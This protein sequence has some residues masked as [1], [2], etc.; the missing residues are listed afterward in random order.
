MGLSTCVFD[1]IH[2]ISSESTKCCP[3]QALIVCR[4]ECVVHLGSLKEQWLGSTS[5]NHSCRF[6]LVMLIRSMCEALR[7]AKFKF[8]GRQKIYVSSKWGFTKWPRADYEKM[9]EERR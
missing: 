2:S 8:P 5:V 1:H 4:L 6:V 3:A 7:R 9:R